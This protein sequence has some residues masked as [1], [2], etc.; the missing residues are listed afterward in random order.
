VVGEDLGTV[1]ESM[2]ADLAERGV[3]S[4]RV[5]W[6]EPEPPTQFPEQALAAVTTHDL[7]TVAGL[8][9]GADLA[10]QKALALEPNEAAAAGLRDRLAASLAEGLGGDA[11]E[12]SVDDVVVG[13][14]RLL[15]GA[16]SAVV[17]ASL[18]DVLAVEE[19]PNMPGTTDGWP[20]WSLALPVPLDD[21][22]HDPRVAAVADLFENRSR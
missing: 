6:F 17:A 2:R 15:A 3:L 22:E 16:P 19:R 10:A 8:W 5:L 4:Y 9:S 21:I 20:N 12:P 11:G 13:V 7:P 18:H 1:E 14:H